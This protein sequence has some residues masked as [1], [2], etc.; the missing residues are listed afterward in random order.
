MRPLLLPT[1]AA[2][3]L[4]AL[5]HAQQPAD[6]TQQ[7]EEDEFL[8]QLDPAEDEDQLD[9]Q[10]SVE[11][12]VV[13]NPA[14][15]GDELWREPQLDWPQ[16]MIDPLRSPRIHPQTPVQL[17]EARDTLAASGYEVLW[18]RAW[19]QPGW[20]REAGPWLRVSGGAPVADRHALEG[21]VQV[22]LSRYLHLRVN[23]WHR[24]PAD[25]GVPPAAPPPLP[26]PCRKAPAR[27][28]PIPMPEPRQGLSADGDSQLSTDGSI[29]PPDD[30]QPEPTDSAADNAALLYPGADGESQL[31]TDGGI[32]PPPED[33]Q[34]EPTD[35]AAHNA[36]W[37]RLSADGDSQLSTDS[38]IP[39]PED[40]PPEPADS[41]A[42]NAAWLY[43]YTDY[44]PEQGGRL[45]GDYCTHASLAGLGWLEQPEPQSPAAE[46][47]A[48]H[49]T[50]FATSRKL[51][52]DQIH[53]LDHPHL[54]IL[55]HIGAAGMDT[56][57]PLP[58]AP[59]DTGPWHHP[60][61]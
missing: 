43:P 25:S 61:P 31:S 22:Y 59:A 15:P 41:A 3:L 45:A 4:A 60:G 27:L 49:L 10:Y 28:P 47:N 54:G 37:P 23:L 56:R 58:P 53:Y 12:L 11:M 39:P 7:P 30:Q 20:E 29:P 46:Q 1:V 19:I 8:E 51:A 33:Q 48:A 14:E 50:H 21:A 42:D 32:P 57:A 17:A 38:G 35:S 40:Q 2:L 9:K 36:A 34:P 6:D 5:A 18:H 44:Q 52:L 55:I 26:M 16:R 13:A 24:Q